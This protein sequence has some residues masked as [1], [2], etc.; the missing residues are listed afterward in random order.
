MKRFLPLLVEHR[1]TVVVV[2][3]AERTI[4]DKEFSLHLAATYRGEMERAGV[5]IRVLLI[6]PSSVRYSFTFLWG[7]RSKPFAGLLH[8]H[9]IVLMHPRRRKLIKAHKELFP[10]SFP[11]GVFSTETEAMTWLIQ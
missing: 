6:C 7:T 9:A 8:A 11:Y 4:V 1:S 3:L 10:G 5:P 2:R